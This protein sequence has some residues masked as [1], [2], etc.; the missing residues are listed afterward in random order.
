MSVW[1][2]IVLSFLS[3]QDVVSMAAVAK[4]N[5]VVLDK[6]G[7]WRDELLEDGGCLA[8]KP[9]G[10][11]RHDFCPVGHG[12]LLFHKLA[13]PFLAFVLFGFLFLNHIIAAPPLTRL[14][15]KFLGQP[16]P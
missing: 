16:S 11:A 13:Q 14:L 10:G 7:D 1:L 15:L 6:A 5:L 12:S 3:S 4:P 8:F 2:A 9:V